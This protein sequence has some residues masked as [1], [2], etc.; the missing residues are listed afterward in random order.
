M[1]L[2]VLQLHQL[3]YGKG[4][5]SVASICMHVLT[6]IMKYLLKG[7]FHSFRLP[8][9]FYAMCDQLHYFEDQVMHN[10]NSILHV[11][12]R[13]S[14]VNSSG[15]GLLPMQQENVPNGR[16]IGS[17]IPYYVIRAEASR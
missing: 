13:F 17:G 11:W 8:K 10:V 15:G 1:Q 5:V 9:F 12:A 3:L 16:A 7:N 4:D 2:L 6:A 14:S